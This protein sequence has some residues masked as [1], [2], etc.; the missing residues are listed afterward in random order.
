VFKKDINQA[1]DILADILKNSKMTKENVERE[2]DVILR[3]A[4]EVEKQHDE[5]VFDHLHATA[6]QGIAQIG[7]KEEDR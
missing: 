7:F 1:V 3:E 4:E 5:T 2:R 6:Y